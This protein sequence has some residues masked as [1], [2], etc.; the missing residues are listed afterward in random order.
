VREFNLSQTDLLNLKNSFINEPLARQMNLFRV[1]SSEGGQLVGRNGTGDYS[2][3]IFPYF[4]PGKDTPCENRLR[5]DNPEIE[6]SGEGE[7]KEKYK[8]LSP[9]GRS[10]LLYFPP[11]CKPEWLNDVSIPIVITEG[12]KKLGALWRVSVFDETKDFSQDLPKNLI[13][14]FF[15][16]GLSGVW[17]WRGT[18]GKSLNSTGKRVDVKGVIPQFNDIVWQNRDVV[19]VFDTNVISND[20]VNAARRK[21]AEEIKSKGAHVF[22]A[23]LPQID[24]INGVDDLLG[25]W[26]RE[27]GLDY[28][29]ENGFRLIQSAKPFEKKTTQ[30]TSILEFVEELE[31]FHTPDRKGFA[32]IEQDGHIEYLSIRSTD[33]R[34]WLSYQFYQREKKMPSAQALQ[35]VINILEGK[36]R[37]NSE[38]KS[39]YLRLASFGNKIYLDLCNADWEIV[40]I[41][42][43]GWRVIKS[44]D[45]P[46]RFRRVSSMQSLPTPKYPG[47]IGKL[48]KYLNANDENITLILAYIVACFR[49]DYPFPVLVLSGEQ[50]TAKSTTSRILRELVDPNQTSVRSSPRDERDLVIAANNCWICA[51][52][53]VSNIPHWL[54]DALCRISTGGGFATRTLY[55]NDEE[56]VFTAKRPIILNGIGDLI[57]RSDLLDRSLLVQLEPIPE[58]RRR[59][60]RDFWKDFEQD[61][62]EVFSGFL[63]AVSSALSQI[64]N[65]KLD[66]LP[67][68]ADF[69]IWATAAESGLG[70]KKGTFLSVYMKNRN[71]AHDIV[72]EGSKIADTVKLFAEK[73]GDFDGTMKEFLQELN[74]LANEETKKDKE[75]PKT[76]RALRSKL[77]RI[78]PNLRA[79]GINILF[80]PRTNK[81]SRIVLENTR[82]QPSQP[83]QPSSTPESRTENNDNS[84]VTNDGSTVNEFSNNHQV[85]QDKISSSKI[86]GD[87]CDDLT[88]ALSKSVPNCPSCELPMTELENEFFCSMGCGSFPKIS[89]DI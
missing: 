70:L 8:Y 62:A 22:F 48:R 19:I 23:D 1:D 9:P 49:P 73:T 40:E 51:F 45:A 35:D 67:R 81:G 24:G 88:P 69:A 26:E 34:D 57:T 25:A 58:N 5:R 56:T 53:N 20:S 66:C 84:T 15:P 44:K 30:A 29:I 71:E 21:L 13:P 60:E 85:S 68:M 38:R 14:K 32:T 61:K 50:G 39:I 27:N 63:S 31:L 65:V 72:L 76:E 2:G 17:N 86:E 33:F 79:I 82:M 41:D 7:L 55:A 47:S 6:R 74:K 37:F 10:N 42:Q 3:I 64:D 18:V 12:E 46:V 75:Y 89:S 43:H 59:S 36:A 78:M 16:I 80:P 28:A 83:S 77:S 4:L 52:D 11:K 54:S 87:G